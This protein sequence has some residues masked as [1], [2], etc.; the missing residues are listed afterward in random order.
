M[1]LNKILTGSGIALLLFGLIS[2]LAPIASAQ[3]KESV[4][5]A[6][7]YHA[8]GGFPFAGLTFDTKGNLYGVSDYGGD[9]NLGICCGV[10]FQ[11][12]PVDS[13]GWTFKVI[14]TFTGPIT[15]G[16]APTGSV[17]VDAS[18][19]LY[20]TTQI[21]GFCGTAY[22]L[23][24]TEA[25]EWKQT[26]L[27]YFN[28]VERGE[29]EDG[30]LPSSSMIFDRA[31]NLYGTTQQTG[32][33]DCMTNAGCGTV[34]E[35]S[36]QADG[37]WKEVVLHHFPAFSGD[38]ISPY[39]ALVMDSTGNLWGTTQ[40]GG[41]AGEGTIFELTPGT[42]GAWN[43]KLAFSFS[44]ANGDLPY[45]GLILDAAGNFYGTTYSGGRNGTGTVYRMTPHAD[46]QLNEKV[47]HNF[48]L[49]NQNQCPDGFAPF[50][51]LVFDAQ[52]NLYGTT[53]LGGGA[54]TVCDQGSTIKVGCGVVFK[55]TP[56]TEDTWTYSIVY[57]FPGDAN[58]G[59]PTDDHLAVDLTG[60]IYGTTLVEGD[61]NSPLCP[62]E[63]LGLGGCGVVFEVS[64]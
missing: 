21:G 8:D 6:F 23:S 38:G 20:G 2:A 10:V 5:H 61:V 22:E 17:V 63:V 45:A 1:R 29:T 62:Q 18:G 47:I 34:F 19:N 43:E 57:R 15:G 16:E 11:L 51:G 44:G 40:F 64:P 56:G 37:K 3:S 36:P 31:G 46:G 27:H 41:S 14:Y 54:S 4:L 39:G 49:C 50:G 42:G 30:C 58:G 53:T 60:N 24:S 13:G 48:A 28:D 7:T 52:G 25:G 9:L 32:A 55:L 35:L 12:T 26:T 59:Y 33:T